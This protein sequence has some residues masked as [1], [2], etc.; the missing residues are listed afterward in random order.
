LTRIAKS[1]LAQ[2][3][4]VHVLYWIVAD[5]LKQSGK[6]YKLEG[7]GSSHLHL[8]VPLI[9]ALGLAEVLE[10]KQVVL[11]L[12]LVQLTHL[13]KLSQQLQER[14]LVEKDT[15][16][17]AVGIELILAFSHARLQRDDIHWN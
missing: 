17:P 3:V 11:F 9:S 14:L 13:F 2:L 5:N 8:L 15:H 10:I 7:L 12:D 1:E 16:T 6:I 4:E